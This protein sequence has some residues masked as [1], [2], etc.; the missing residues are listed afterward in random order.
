MTEVK[1]VLASDEEGV[2]LTY[3]LIGVGAGI[4]V[5]VVCSLVV[6]KLFRIKSNQNSSNNNTNYA[7]STNSTNMTRN[8]NNSCTPNNLII[9]I[10]TEGSDIQASDGSTNQFDLSFSTNKSGESLTFIHFYAVK[11]YPTLDFL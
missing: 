2:S 9:T 10:K 5:L 8:S 1:Y 7:N 3:I 11:V 4:V 6:V